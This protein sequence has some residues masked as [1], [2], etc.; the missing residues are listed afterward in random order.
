MIIVKEIMDTN[1]LRSMKVNHILQK[2]HKF[3]CL[4]ESVQTKENSVTQVKCIGL[5]GVTKG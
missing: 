1:N 4:K 2:F 3:L 5:T